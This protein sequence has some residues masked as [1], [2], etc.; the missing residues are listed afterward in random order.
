MSDTQ[1][2]NTVESVINEA[3]NNGIETP[4]AANDDEQEIPVFTAEQMEIH[5]LANF[6]SLQVSQNPM[7]GEMQMGIV[8]IP[9]P[10]DMIN[11]FQEQMGEEMAK[12]NMKFVIYK[13]KAF[14]AP[15]KT[16]ALLG[17]A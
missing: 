13:G 7:T 12:E 5:N 1:L 10:I 14:L 15:V 6:C 4:E 16:T 9:V 8:Q 3:F 2:V 11:A 17:F